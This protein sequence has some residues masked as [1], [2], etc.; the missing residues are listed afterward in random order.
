METV[1]YIPKAAA[2]ACLVI[3]SILIGS[4]N[5]DAGIVRLNNSSN[6]APSIPSNP[7]PPNDTT[8]IV[9]TSVTLRWDCFD[10]DVGDT[11]RFDVYFDNNNPPALAAD[12]ILLRV[13]D[14]GILDSGTY[15]WKITAIDKIGAT[16][17][18]PIWKFTVNP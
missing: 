7:Y 16:S 3:F 15:F 13:Y 12:S 17:V 11:V 10:N 14:I 4:C 6:F 9:G 1:K 5:N 8:L 18:G 2:F